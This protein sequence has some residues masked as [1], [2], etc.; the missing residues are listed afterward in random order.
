MKPIISI[1]TPSFNQ[2]EFLEDTIKSVL[3]QKGA[4][5]IDFIIKDGGSTDDSKEIIK[6]FEKLLKENCSTFE[7]NGL[8]F[9]TNYSKPP[10]EYIKCLGVSY[11]WV[12]QRDGGQVAAI[13][14]GVNDSIG[15]WI[16]WLNSDDY[17]IRDDSLEIICRTAKAYPLAKLITADCTI[18]DRHGKKLWEHAIGRISI[19]ELIYLDY[20]IAQVSTFI[21][22]EVFN[23]FNLERHFRCTFDASFFTNILKNGTPFVKLT[24]S[25][26][27]FRM[28]GENLTDNP[29]LRIKTFKERAQ[30]MWKYSDSVFK[31]SIALVYQF[32]AIVLQ[33]RFSSGSR[34]ERLTHRFLGIYRKVCYHLILGENYS[35]RYK[36]KQPIRPTDTV[37]LSSEYYD[38]KEIPLVSAIIPSYNS[39]TTLKRA[40]DSLLNQDLPSIEIIIVDDASTDD[41]NKFVR[42]HYSNNNKVIY[43]LNTKNIKLAATRNVGLELASGKYVFFLD[44]DDWLDKG[45]LLHMALVAEKTAADIVSCAVRMTFEDGTEKEFHNPPYFICCGGSEALEKYANYEIGSIVWNKLYLRAFINYNNLRFEEF[46]GHEDVMFTAESLYKCAKYVSLDN[47]YH[48]YFQREDSYTKSIPTMHHLQS[49]IRL[50]LN[51]TNFISKYKLICSNE[52]NTLVKKLVQAHCSNE[53]IPKI[54]R[55]AATRTQF[56]W[57]RECYLAFEKELGAPGYACA[58]FLIN[59]LKN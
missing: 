25:L 33:K 31:Y 48:N 54:K 38:Q 43:N 47:V 21:T 52:N 28:Y 23:D 39:I 51:M 1:V 15:T 42:E 12:S 9:F 10:F 57:E 55:Y 41:T 44:A 26:G 14:D 50:Y 4:F 49:Y 16:G 27:A 53:L 3:I 2:G 6:K 36:L 5:Y 8:T 30:Y 24:V 40:V 20:H 46:Y 45:A 37:F 59:I 35:S 58:D 32:F 22:R 56:E 7:L 29:A 11:R 18:V 13:S 17:F 19:P 34:A